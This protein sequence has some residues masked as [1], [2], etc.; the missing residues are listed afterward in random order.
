ME[1][2]MPNENLNDFH[3]KN[4][5]EDVENLSGEI[6]T[7]KNAS[8]EKLH[9]RLRQKPHGIKSAWYWAAAACLLFILI[10][11]LLTANKRQGNLVKNNPGK[12]L[13]EKGS[14]PVISPLK[15]KAVVIISPAAT[16]KRK[17][18]KQ[19]IHANQRISKA[20]DIVKKEQILSPDV[21]RL[22]DIQ[23]VNAA[24]PAVIDS[25]FK[26][27]LAIKSSNKKLKVIHINELGG[28]LEESATIVRYYERH[29]LQLKLI[30]TPVYTSAALSPNNRGFGFIKRKITSN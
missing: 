17:I 25:V 11:P 29:S 6:L 30:N 23:S 9:S 21:T 3:W 28:T 15:E 7:D 26:T 8:W 4:K 22:K 19:A 12:T 27:S 13:S 14:A 20:N 16:G 10:I 18:I 2:N 1:T 24:S 5:L